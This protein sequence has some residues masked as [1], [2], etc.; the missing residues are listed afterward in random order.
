M[1][2]GYLYMLSKLVEPI[3]CIRQHMLVRPAAS[4]INPMGLVM[5]G[6]SSIL[7]TFLLVTEVPNDL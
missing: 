5:L 7:S 4:S 2:V 6:H 1:Y 3:M